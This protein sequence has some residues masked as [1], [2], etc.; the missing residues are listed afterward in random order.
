M[1]KQPK[2]EKKD[3]LK[4]VYIVKEKNIKKMLEY[5]KKQIKK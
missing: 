1:E 2:K 3:A 4:D 5:L